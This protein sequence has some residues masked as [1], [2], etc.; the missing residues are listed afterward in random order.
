MNNIKIPVFFSSLT[1]KKQH[2]SNQTKSKKH[3][4]RLAV[5]DNYC[6]FAPALDG[7][8]IKVGPIAQLVRAP[9]S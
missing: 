5:P 7:N 2:T 3:V 1:Q 6:N 4:M 9:D 8:T